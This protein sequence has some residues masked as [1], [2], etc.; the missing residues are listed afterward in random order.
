VPLDSEAVAEWLA[1]AQ[2]PPAEPGRPDERERLLAMRAEILA[3]R[4]R[5]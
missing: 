2:E 4:A 1:D 3:R 5:A